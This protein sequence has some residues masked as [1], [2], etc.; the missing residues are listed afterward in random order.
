MLDNISHQW[1]AHQNHNKILFHTH[2]S[3]YNNIKKKH[4]DRC[5]GKD[6]RKL[7]RSYIAGSNVKWLSHFG[8]HLE[9]PQKVRVTTW[10]TNS[11]SSYV[12]KWNEL[13]TQN[14]YINRHIDTDKSAMMVR[15][16]GVLALG[17][18]QVEGWGGSEWEYL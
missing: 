11:I 14:L 1:K 9:V 10:P 12:S 13:S 17:K 8:K 18:R 16:K 3:T 15:G 6:M 4:K 7:E 2:N 5:V